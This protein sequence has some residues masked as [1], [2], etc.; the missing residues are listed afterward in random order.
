MT[1][2][3]KYGINSL[4]KEEIKL[5]VE[6]LLHSSCINVYSTW[7]DEHNT[8][9]QDLAIKIRKMFPEILCENTFLFKDDVISDKNSED[10]LKYFPELTKAQDHILFTDNVY[11]E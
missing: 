3:I 11:V 5:L 9:M 2:N 1:N 7:Y 6:S 4:E 10:L 8:K